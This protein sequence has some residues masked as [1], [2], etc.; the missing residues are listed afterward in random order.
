MPEDSNLSTRVNCGTFV[1]N[2]AALSLALDYCG[3]FV[4]TSCTTEKQVDSGLQGPK[5]FY[6]ET[7]TYG[8]SYC[9]GYW[10]GRYGQELF[11][12]SGYYWS[13]PLP[14]GCQYI[15]NNTVI[16]CF[17]SFGPQYISG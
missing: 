12:P 2:D 17:Q 10:R 5:D 11:A 13:S 8:C 4:L 1:L 15:V 7:L 14:A 9:D 3:E 6:F 16:A